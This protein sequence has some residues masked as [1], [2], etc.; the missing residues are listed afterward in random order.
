M[1]S[2]FPTLKVAFVMIAVATIW[3]NCQSASAQVDLQA[4]AR[5]HNQTQ[6]ANVLEFLRPTATGDFVALLNGFDSTL[7]DDDERRRGLAMLSGEAG[8]GQFAYRMGV[9]RQFDDMIL[10]QIRPIGPERP[11]FMVGNPNLTAGPGYLGAIAGDAANQ[12]YYV[13][14]FPSTWIRVFGMESNSD[15]D[16][17]E[18]VGFD[19]DTVGTMLGA[20]FPAN[21]AF[22]FGFA[23]GF[24]RSNAT[25][26]RNFGGQD[27]D[28]WRGTLYGR[29]VG[30]KFYFLT[31]TSFGYDRYKTARDIAYCQIFRATFENDYDGH[32]YTYFWEL[33]S[34]FKPCCDLAIQPLMGMR[35]VRLWRDGYTE[36]AGGAANL[37]VDGDSED[38]LEFRLGGRLVGRYKPWSHLMLLPELRMWWLHDFLADQ[39]GTTVRFVDAPTLPMNITGA[40]PDESYGVVGLGLTMVFFNTTSLY[41]NYDGAFGSRQNIHAGNLGFLVTW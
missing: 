2:R 16:V 30:E 38:A 3:S 7:I 18:P 26:D 22:L 8:V 34:T 5:T 36:S 19:T 35:Y 20:S 33:G 41:F 28:T 32:E 23:G 9:S 13:G 27:L 15:I 40:A 39:S 4:L 25:A 31:G 37:I 17:D 29:Y 1:M 12:A 21:D 24:S 6:V 14:P 10:H 11:G